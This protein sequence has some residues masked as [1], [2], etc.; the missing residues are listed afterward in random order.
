MAGGRYLNIEIAAYLRDTEGL[1]AT[2]SGAYLH[3]LMFATVHGSIPIDDDESL[4][5]ITRMTPQ[6]WR[7]GKPRLLKF[8]DITGRNPRVERERSR[9]ERI[10]LLRAFAGREGGKAS[11]MSRRARGKRVDN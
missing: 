9:A 6:Q 8:F 11:G 3:L 4:R 1:S 10:S 5:I 2:L 7:R